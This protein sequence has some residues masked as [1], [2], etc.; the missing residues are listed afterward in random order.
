MPCAVVA[1]A[2]VWS[3]NL[4]LVPWPYLIVD[5]FLE[6]SVL[7]DCLNE[8]KNTYSFDVEKRGQSQIEYSL[9][10]STTLWNALYSRH[11]IYLLTAAFGAPV[12]LSRD[13]WIQL[14]RMNSDSPEFPLHHDFVTAEDS[15]VSFL[16]LS[17][18]WAPDCGGRLHL[19][20][21]VDDEV[22]VL[23]VA[24]IQNRLVAFQTK[25]CHWH[26]VER[27]FGWERVSALALWNVVSS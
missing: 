7:E 11:T 6:R 9:L 20:K 19:Y 10:K 22:P 23:S 3:A 21:T 5:N 25:A 12:A 1:N 27:V 16:Y 4:N 14:R 13:N 8:I 18:G 15:V 2:E 26:A 24:P 17:A